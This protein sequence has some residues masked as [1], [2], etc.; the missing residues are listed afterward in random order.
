MRFPEEF[1]IKEG[2]LVFFFLLVEDL[3]L[4]LLEKLGLFFS[5]LLL[6]F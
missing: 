2:V 6:M 5:E 3:A 4:R 1:L